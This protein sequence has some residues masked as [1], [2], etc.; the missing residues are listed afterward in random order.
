MCGVG[1]SVVCVCMCVFTH[2]HVTHVGL[3][4]G[5]CVCVVYVWC[6]CVYVCVFTHLDVTHIRFLSGVCPHVLFKATQLVVHLAAALKV[7][8]EVAVLLVDPRVG[9]HTVRREEHL[10]TTLDGT[11][12]GGKHNRQ[13]LHIN[14]G[15]YEKNRYYYSILCK[16]LGFFFNLIQY[17]SRFNILVLVVSYWVTKYES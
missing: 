13:L 9:P 5:M 16:V 11:S 12:G 4:S 14:R 10:V 15:H 7:T 1:V 3:L 8:G 2:L 6:V 17:V